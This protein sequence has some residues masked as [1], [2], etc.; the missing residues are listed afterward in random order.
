MPLHP[1]GQPAVPLHQEIIE[2]QLV[3][4]EIQAVIN[5]SNSDPF[6]KVFSM[7]LTTY[8]GLI[9]SLNVLMGNDN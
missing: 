3:I 2:P 6:L 9:C 1:A 7:L 4:I 5:H 8:F